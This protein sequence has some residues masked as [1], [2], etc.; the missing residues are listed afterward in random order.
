MMTT[1]SLSSAQ[2]SA[3]ICYS[4]DCYHFDKIREKQDKLKLGSHKHV[5]RMVLLWFL[6]TL[7]VRNL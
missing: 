1:L 3:V 2:F 7:D 4:Y 5:A 6:R